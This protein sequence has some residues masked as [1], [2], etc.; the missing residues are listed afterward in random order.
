MTHTNAVFFFPAWW[1]QLLWSPGCTSSCGEKRT[2]WSGAASR[3]RRRRRRSHA[4]IRVA[5]SSAPP[6]RS[7]SCWQTPSQASSS[8]C[9][10]ITTTL[11]YFVW[12]VKTDRQICAVLLFMTSLPVVCS[13]IRAASKWP[14]LLKMWGRIADAI[15]KYD[16]Y[17]LR[18]ILSVTINF[19]YVQL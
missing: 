7:L 10:H 19:F 16:W 17:S 6:L 18:L 4:R 12:L 2:T 13:D 8:D 1:E 5:T 14:D 15:M 9:L 11:D 3:R